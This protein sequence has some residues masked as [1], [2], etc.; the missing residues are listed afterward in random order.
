LIAPAAASA[1]LSTALSKAEARAAI[2]VHDAQKYRELGT[3]IK[4]CKR[5]AANRVKCIV[6]VPAESVACPAGN[7]STPAHSWHDVLTRQ[8]IHAV[9]WQGPIEYTTDTVTE[10]GHTVPNPYVC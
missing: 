4:S 5:L 8:L 9:D 6:A 10:H 3:Y 1:D 2:L 7:F